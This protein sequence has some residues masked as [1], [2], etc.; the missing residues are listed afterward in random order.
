[1]ADTNLPNGANSSQQ[2]RRGGRKPGLPNYQNNK[3]ILIIERILP[4]GSEALHLVAIVY[5]EES[6]EEALQTEEDLR[7]NWVSCVTTTKSQLV[8]QVSLQTVFIAALK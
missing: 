1:M 4:N 7:R 6:G 3:I 2:K 8:P 5:K